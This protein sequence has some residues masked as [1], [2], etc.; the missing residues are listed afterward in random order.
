MNW[1]SLNVLVCQLKL[2]SLHFICFVIGCSF[3]WVVDLHDD[4]LN[5]Q[6][7][8]YSKSN[9]FHTKMSARFFHFYF[10]AQIQTCPANG[11]FNGKSLHAMPLT[12]A[13]ALQHVWHSKAPYGLHLLLA[14]PLPPTFQSPNIGSIQIHNKLKDRNRLSNSS[15]KIIRAIDP[16]HAHTAMHAHQH[17]EFHYEPKLQARQFHRT[18]DCR[19]ETKKEKSSKHAT[20]LSNSGQIFEYP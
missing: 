14:L 19:M 3:R 11:G 12:W 6:T 13:Y 2:V 10:C 18:C 8:D 7:F 1:L 17:F 5:S 15:N 16:K 20:Y 4:L 9:S